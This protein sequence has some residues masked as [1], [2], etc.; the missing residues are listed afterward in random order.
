[1]LISDGLLP[2]ST[3]YELRTNDESLSRDFNHIK[4][5]DFI[6]W[7]E[8]FFEIIG[9]EA[10]IECIQA[11]PELR[12]VHEAPVYVP[13]SNELLFADTSAVGWLWAIDIDTHRASA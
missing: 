3:F 11:F 4:T 12:H 10:K 13:E 9:P 1:M 8:S 2:E 6:A 7:D 5:A